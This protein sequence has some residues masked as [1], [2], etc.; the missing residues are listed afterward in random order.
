MGASCPKGPGVTF[1]LLVSYLACLVREDEQDS[2]NSGNKQMVYDFFSWNFI[3]VWKYRYNK[4]IGEG[5]LEGCIVFS[6]PFSR[7]SLCLCS[8]CI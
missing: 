2:R 1:A 5:A 3:K 8:V 4:I 6:P 7:T